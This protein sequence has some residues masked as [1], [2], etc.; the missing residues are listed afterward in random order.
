M[1]DAVRPAAHHDAPALA[2]RLVDVIDLEPDLPVGVA[3]DRGT[4]GRS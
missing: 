4:L 1:R 3:V 2:E